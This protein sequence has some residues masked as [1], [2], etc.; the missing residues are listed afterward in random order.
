MRT[1]FYLRI[2]LDKTGEELA[3]SRQREDCQAIAEKRGW[4]VVGEYVD[5]SI[6]A[7]DTRKNRPGY[8]A[9][10][11]AYESG[12]FDALICWDLDRLTRQPRQL[13]DWIDA[14]EGRGLAIVTANGEADLT[15]DGGRL[16]ARM[17][18]AVARS[19]VDRKG[20]RQRRAGRQRA[21][22][23]KRWGPRRAFGFE[24]DD[25]L[26]ETEAAA[27]K[28]AYS[29]VLRGASLGSIATSWNA[30]GLPTT[31]GNRWRSAQVRQLLLNA[32][33]AGLRSYHG[34]V[35]AEADHPAIVD[36]DTWREVVAV[37]SDPARRCGPTRGRKYLL[38]GIVRCGACGGPM[39]SGRTTSRPAGALIYLCKNPGCMKVS[40]NLERVDA[41]VQAAV[42]ARLSRPDAAAVIAHDDD[43]DAT[44]AALRD[45]AAL[46][47]SKLDTLAAMFTDDELTESQMRTG[48]K[49]LKDKLAVIEPRLVE[50][51]RA[52][53]FAGVIGADDVAAAFDGLGL[54]RQRAVIDTLATVT[55]NP[56]GRGR[57]F[58]PNL[59]VLDW[60]R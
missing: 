3:V 16:F 57:G 26:N 13:E 40:R 47:R 11:T 20:A 19:E 54:D 46:L 41:A 14:A 44:R 42:V 45:E 31:L 24:A 51:E 1:A 28:A 7:S 27:I 8:D 35:V 2:S 52:R 59:I 5:N 22:S 29:E 56:A 39:G 53:V 36:P 10:V 30:A 55:I 43:D 50:P 37:L 32:R 12:E 4:D 38:T 21:E 9:L 15:T 23:G 34:K 6:S 48:T 25:S 49:R 58:D 18:T 17:K 33:N 60:K